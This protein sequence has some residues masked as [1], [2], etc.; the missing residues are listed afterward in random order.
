MVI[1]VLDKEI[2]K[3]FNDN[4]KQHQDGIILTVMDKNDKTLYNGIVWPNEQYEYDA[5]K[6]G[7]YKICVKMTDSMFIPTVH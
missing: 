6:G 4:L 3:N 2:V 7:E 5:E 1:N